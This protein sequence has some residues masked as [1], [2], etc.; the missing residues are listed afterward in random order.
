M[1]REQ[2]EPNEALQGRDDLFN[3]VQRVNLYTASVV[4][5][6]TLSSA[7]YGYAGSII[8]TTLTQPSFITHMKLD[9]APNA[10][11]IEGAMN[12]LFYTGGVLGSFFAGWSS[13]RFGRKFSTGFGNALLVI[14]GACMTAS[15]NPT[16]FIAFRF[17]S[18][19][20]YAI[21]LPSDN[22]YHLPDLLFLDF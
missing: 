1:R 7:A 12:A 5:F 4:S 10:E 6:I 22:C 16:M 19:F 18:G 13:K 9:T 20:G 15:I 2:P 11:A 21:K 14:S 3:N 17:V 8:A